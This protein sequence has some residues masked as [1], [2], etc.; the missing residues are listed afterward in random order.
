MEYIYQ[1]FTAL[2]CTYII[3]LFVVILFIK[4]SSVK[5]GFSAPYI[6][7]FFVVFLASFATLPYLWFVWPEFSHNLVAAEGLIILME[8]LIYYF[9]LKLSFRSSLIVSA[10]A[11]LISYA[12]GLLFFQ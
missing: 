2:A 8:S 12:T 1:F 10:I 4:Y 7:I 3:E 6:N 11:N 5:T 9:C